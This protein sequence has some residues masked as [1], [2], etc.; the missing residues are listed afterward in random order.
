M[1][2][3]KFIKVNLLPKDSFEVSFLGKFLKWSLTAGR[4]MVVLTEFVVILAFSSRF[5]FDKELNDLREVNDSLQTAIQSYVD[6][7]NQMRQVI[8]RQKAVDIF[9]S[10]E[11]KTSEGLEKLKLM[12]PS[13]TVLSQVSFLPGGVGIA[14]VTGSEQ[15]LAQTINTMKSYEDLEGVNIKKIEFD[16]KKGGLAFEIVSQFKQVKK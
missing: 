7:E 2:A 1:P 6:V 3:K 13:G 9:L 4:V 14:G 5:W 16:Q 15:S 10:E 11:L 8:V 12:L